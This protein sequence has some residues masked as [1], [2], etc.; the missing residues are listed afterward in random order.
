MEDVIG[1]NITETLLVKLRPLSFSIIGHGILFLA[2]INLR[3]QLTSPEQK[4]IKVIQ[5][6][7]YNVPAAEIE[8]R[9]L[10]KR[11]EPIPIQDQQH[12]E[13]NETTEIEQK[14][15]L[16]DKGQQS[17]ISEKNNKGVA[18]AAT[19]K[20]IIDHHSNKTSAVFSSSKTLESLKARIE[21]QSYEQSAQQNYSDYIKAKN[22]IS[23][24]TTKFKEITEAKAKTVNVNCKSTLN[25]GVMILSSLL[26]GSVKCTNFNGSQKFIDARLEK[27]GKKKGDQ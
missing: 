23:R 15:Q 10:S 2:I 17:T 3:P 14:P 22:T 11:H 1:N 19:N 24:S 21:Q 26:G 13:I 18:N 16:D 9:E 4:I 27:L 12:I 5:A 8:N 20:N 6:R 25:K 7:L